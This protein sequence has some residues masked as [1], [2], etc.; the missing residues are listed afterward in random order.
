[1]KLIFVVFLTFCLGVSGT[2]VG[3]AGAPAKSSAQQG[4]EAQTVRT[5]LAAAFCAIDV[6]GKTFRVLPWDENAR[7]WKRDSVRVLAWNDQ[8]RLLSGTHTLTMPQLIS[9]KPLDDGS[10]DIA[11][12]RGKRGAFYIAAIEGKEVVQKVE[13]VGLF[14]NEPIP[15]VGG[16]WG[17]QILGVPGK[18]S[19]GKDGD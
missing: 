13:L 1:M 10:K 9:G 15:A 18:V 5:P 19:C 4:Q 16:N 7:K 6:A 12:I 8:T 14:A 2:A 3:Q 17:A 11:D